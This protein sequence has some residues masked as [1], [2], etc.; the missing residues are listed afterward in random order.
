M[1]DSWQA[2]DGNDRGSLTAVSNADG[3]TIIRLQADPITHRLLVDLPSSSG[4]VTEVDTGTGLTG[5]PITTTGTISLDTKLAPMDSLTGNSLKVLRVN[6]G[7]TAVEYAT[8]TTGTVTTTGTPASGNLTKFSG[9]TSVTNGDLSGDITTTGTLA[10]TLATVNSNVGS[11]TNASITVNGKGLVTAAASGTAPV[12]SIS[13]ATANG[14]AGNSSGGATPALTLSTT[15]TGTL[16]GNGTA[17]SASK[18]TLTQPATGSTL[19]IVDGKTLTV[20]NTLALSGTDSTVMT[21]PTTTAT[22][23]RTDAAQTFTGTQ[24]FAQTIQ[25]VQAITVASN[26]GTADVTH[27]NQTFTN[28]S[29]ATM[30]ITIATTSAVDGQLKIIRIYDFS[31]VTQ[32]IGWTNTEDSTVTAPTTSNGSTTLPLTVG[33]Q[34]NGSTSK[35]RTIAKA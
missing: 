3:K 6:V 16:Q 18:V 22:I 13:V 32:T 30:A 28:S 21:F 4:T 23:A 29:A 10:T 14:L 5:G 25:T 34:F 12:T 19:T 31:A 9:T 15:I 11:F 24:T 26:A 7:E 2:I 1:S 20:N 33:F 27:G 35:W 8:P 17:I